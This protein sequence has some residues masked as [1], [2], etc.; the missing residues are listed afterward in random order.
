M[1][2]GQQDNAGKAREIKSQDE[3]ILLTQASAMVDGVYQDIFE[4]LKPGVRESDIVALA[5]KRLYEMGSEH[6]EADQLH[7]RG[8][9]Q[10]ASRMCSP[11]VSSGRVTLPTSTSSRPH[12]GY[13]TCYYRTFG[14]G[15][16]TQAQRD[17]YKKAR[18]WID[19]AIALVK[20]GTTTDKIALSHGRKPRSSVFSDEM[21]AFG[22]QFGHGVGLW[23]STSGR[24]S[25]ASIPS[26]TPIELKE[27]M[28]FAL[29]TFCPAADGR[30]AARIEETGRLYGRRAP[31]S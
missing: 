1:R 18:E 17:A 21:E 9:V 11:T 28:F 13:R 22:L 15:R 27:G 3:I 29:E 2:N 20:P 4:A 6:V 10:P 25:A 7:C 26:T 19:A 5:N 30:S 8:A 31:R 16:A 24:L 14:V 12:N 23:R